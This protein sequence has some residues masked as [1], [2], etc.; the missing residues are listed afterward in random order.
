MGGAGLGLSICSEIVDAHSGSIT[1]KQSS[2]GGLEI[3]V[4]LNKAES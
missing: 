4:K 1:A 2:I 3:I